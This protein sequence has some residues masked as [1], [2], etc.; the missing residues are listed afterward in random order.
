MGA[1]CETATGLR[2]GRRVAV[3]SGV[4]EASGEPVHERRAWCPTEHSAGQTA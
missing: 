2:D 4:F 1:H 3:E